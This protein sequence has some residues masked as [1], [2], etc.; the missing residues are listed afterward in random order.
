[1]YSNYTLDAGSMTVEVVPVTEDELVQLLCWDKYGIST[2][3]RKRPR[4]ELF[5]AQC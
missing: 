2:F 1:M 3:P 5:A 4:F